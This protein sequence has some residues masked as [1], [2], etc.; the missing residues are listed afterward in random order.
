M[1]WKSVNKLV[2]KVSEIADLI[3]L[4]EIYDLCGTVCYKIDYILA[5]NAR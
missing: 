2:R 4:Y 3:F 5:K 1:C